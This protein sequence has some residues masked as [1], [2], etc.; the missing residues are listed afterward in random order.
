MTS[1]KKKHLFLARSRKFRD[2]ITIAVNSAQRA[3]KMAMQRSD[4]AISRT[5]TASDRAQNA[6]I[7]ADQA[8]IDCE[9]AVSTARGFA[10]DF[11][12]SV[13][14]RFQ[15]LF[16]R[17]YTKLAHSRENSTVLRYDG[18]LRTP[19]K[20]VLLMKEQNEPDLNLS[21][22]Q[23][24]DIPSNS[25]LPQ[26]LH[27]TPQTDFVNLV[28][29]SSQSGNSSFVQMYPSQIKC[30]E[31]QYKQYQENI[32]Q[33]DFIRK[34]EIK[35]DNSNQENISSLYSHR[36]GKDYI[37]VGQ[38]KSNA[39]ISNY[40]SNANSNQ[41]DGYM[42]NNSEGRLSM[43]PN[44]PTTIY[45]EQQTS[46]QQNS[47]Q[48]FTQP[49]PNQNSQF[50]RTTPQ[51]TE[52]LGDV[53]KPTR[54]PPLNEI[55]QQLSID[56]FDHYKRPPSR[57][58]SSDRYPRAASYIS[59]R[60]TSID[61]SMSLQSPDMSSPNKEIRQQEG[62]HNQESASRSTT[63]KAMNNFS[64]QMHNAEEK[65]PSLN[66]PFEDVLLHQRTLGQDIIPS[67]ITPKRTESLYTPAKVIIPK[68]APAN[69]H[70]YT[71]SKPVKVCTYI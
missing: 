45:N 31:E 29:Q 22:Q 70:N 9:I 16:S 64:N 66:Q 20:S 18:N 71:G 3:L 51:K 48:T 43:V 60:Q 14:E 28:N 65:R 68:I 6:D 38:S 53:R 24:S 62:S 39:K 63:N 4:I 17:N 52:I 19:H 1:Q 11:K 33:H 35:V 61:R 25:V 41:L 8:R 7:A 36:M 13:L 46:H 10:P 32:Q 57:D 56:Y 21:F 69:Y 55:N 5:S 67:A 2:R 50:Y 54:P 44:D 47:T 37:T 34:N 30:N 59:S 26:K 58:S 49:L 42:Y 27:V 40:I 12:S 23:Q 15:K